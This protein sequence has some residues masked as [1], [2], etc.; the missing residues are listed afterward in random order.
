MPACS[1]TM[2]KCGCDCKC[3]WRGVAR[4]L[5]VD[6]SK[7]VP[8]VAAVLLGVSFGI[9]ASIFPTVFFSLVMGFWMWSSESTLLYFQRCSFFCCCA[10]GCG[11]QIL[12]FYMFSR[13]LFGVFRNLQSYISGGDP[14]FVAVPL[15]VNLGIYASPRSGPIVDV[16]GFRMKTIRYVSFEHCIFLCGVACI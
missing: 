16:S 9:Y 11:L 5:Q 2:G 6:V 8:S 7:S 1:E 14:S 15:G 3:S 12:R 10:S 13:V 4:N